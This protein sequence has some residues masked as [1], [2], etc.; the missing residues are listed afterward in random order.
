MLRR[1]GRI[2]KQ[3]ENIFALAFGRQFPPQSLCVV[4]VPT[5]ATNKTSLDVLDNGFLW[6]VPRSRRSVEKRLS[7][8]FGY[9]EYVYKLLLPKRN[10]LV[11]NT[12]G[13]HYEANHLCP[14]CYAKVRTETEAMQSTIQK[15][16]GL[17]PVEQEVVVI[18]EGEKVEQ[19]AEFWKGKRVIE[20]KKERPSW[21]S[22]NLLEK[23][24]VQ[25]SSGGDVKPTELA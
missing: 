23:S 16:L 4:A 19:P 6:A 21:F 7:R 14:H 15:E 2:L 13:H 8:K 9:P 11:C 24:T 20:M 25:P 22:K 1:V 5:N 17:N 3:I 12:C 18:Y 10:L